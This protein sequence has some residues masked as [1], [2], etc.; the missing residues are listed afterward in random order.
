[1][2]IQ[3]TPWV[4]IAIGP[5]HLVRASFTPYL[6]SHQSAPRAAIAGVIRNPLGRSL[7]PSEWSVPSLTDTLPIPLKHRLKDYPI[8]TLRPIM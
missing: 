1:M 7:S 3:P 5:T 2:G 6:H 4:P 8:N